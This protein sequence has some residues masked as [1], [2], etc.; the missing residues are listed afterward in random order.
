MSYCNFLFFAKV[1][2]IVQNSIL[3]WSVTWIVS[4]SHCSRWLVARYQFCSLPRW[5]WYLPK[6]S[7]WYS[8]WPKRSEY[9]PGARIPSFRS[10]PAG[11][12]NNLSLNVD[13]RW[14][15]VRPCIDSSEL[16]V[17]FELGSRRDALLAST[18]FTSWSII[19]G[20]LINYI[21]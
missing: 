4:F 21:S 6:E 16:C 9:F 10:A 7:S 5:Y 1:R 18:Y 2:K 11:R 12:N 13:A 20:R 3:T 19:R 17:A 8:H 14:I 15:S